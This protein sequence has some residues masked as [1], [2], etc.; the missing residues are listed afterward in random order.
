MKIPLFVWVL[1][2]ASLFLLTAWKPNP[3]AGVSALHSRSFQLTGTCNG[4]D[5]VY[6]W[7]INGR[8][9]GGGVPP[10]SGDRGASFIYPWVTSDI[11][12]RAVEIVEI[13]AAP[14][15]ALPRYSFLMLGNNA[16][17]DAMLFLDA[18]HIYARHDFPAGTGFEFPG[19]SDGDALTYIDLHGSCTD[20]MAAT[21]L[22]T[23]YYTIP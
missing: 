12:I 14:G 8:G 18:D 15:A 4:R 7:S 16:D 10:A 17:Q 6:S 21:V 3:P 20:Q 23:F 11:T 13:P 19:S 1:S 5:M 22:C 9:G 2:V